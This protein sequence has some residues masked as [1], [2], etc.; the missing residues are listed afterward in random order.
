[1]LYWY[2]QVL[3]ALCTNL[4]S[5][6]PVSRALTTDA[7]IKA[8]DAPIQTKFP[9]HQLFAF[10]PGGHFAT[11]TQAVLCWQSRAAP[12]GLH[13]TGSGFPLLL[14]H[15]SLSCRKDAARTFR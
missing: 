6:S 8:A 1:M 5:S 4:N 9:L 12:G 10:A 14:K 15:F 3:A 13:S 2:L 7:F 11:L